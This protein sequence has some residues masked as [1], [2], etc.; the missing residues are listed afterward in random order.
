[1]EN[2]RSNSTRVSPELFTFA[3][4]SVVIALLLRSISPLAEQP[5]LWSGAMTVL[6][7]WVLFAALLHLALRFVG[8]KAQFAVTATIIIQVSALSTYCVMLLR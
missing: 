5:S 3:V 7:F 2:G 8:G 6:V 1:L 4:L